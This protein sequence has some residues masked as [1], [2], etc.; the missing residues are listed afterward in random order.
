MAEQKLIK[1]ENLSK[2][3]KTQ[4]AEIEAL[5][6]ITL[7]VGFGE[8]VAIMGPPGSGKTTLMKIIGCLEESTRGAYRFED[9]DIK[10][11]SID[12]IIKI[13]DEKIEFEDLT[14]AEKEIP[15]HK[16]SL[17]IIDEPQ[18][19]VDLK[20]SEELLEFLNKLNKAGITIILATNE[21][22]LAT[23]VKRIITMRKGTKVAD[24]DLG[25]FYKIGR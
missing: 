10:K 6:D 14:D 24:V 8:F 11:L 16:V 20:R 25:I 23:G 22:K 3:Y 1:I 17:I 15:K 4:D 13:R 21:K 7:E 5:K 9:R 12:E 2:V 18:K 19:A